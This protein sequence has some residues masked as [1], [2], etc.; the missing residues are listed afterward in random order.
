MRAMGWTPG[1][2]LGRSG[3][4]GIT[5]PVTV[6]VRASRTGLGI[7][8][9]PSKNTFSKYYGKYRNHNGFSAGTVIPASVSF[10]T[11]SSS[12]SSSV[13][14]S[15]SSTNTYLAHQEKKT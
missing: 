12:A 5:E 13:A 7:A 11:S 10:V 3:E 9:I 1:K 4:G 14:S 2:A 15:L 8:G 6:T